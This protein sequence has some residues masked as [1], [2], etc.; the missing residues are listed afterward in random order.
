MNDFA[1]IGSAGKNVGE[2]ADHLAAVMPF[3]AICLDVGFF[4]FGRVLSSAGLMG[5]GKRYKAAFKKVA[6]LVY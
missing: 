2:M 5:R 6:I 1:I 3:S 4:V